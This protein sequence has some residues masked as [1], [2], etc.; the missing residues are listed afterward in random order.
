MEGGLQSLTSRDA[1]LPTLALGAH[2]PSLLPRTSL[3]S[4]GGVCLRGSR[5][6]AA[7]GTLAGRPEPLQVLSPPVQ[8]APGP[9][10]TRG[11]APDLSMLEPFK[12]PSD[13]SRPRQVG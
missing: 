2:L 9:A 13:T 5:L 6:S 11:L 12:A 10:L 1:L 7:E 8:G 3:A 4:R